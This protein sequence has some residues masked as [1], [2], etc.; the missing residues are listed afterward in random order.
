VSVIMDPVTLLVLL[1]VGA[2][3]SLLLWKVRWLAASNAILFSTL[4]AALVVYWGL[5][6]EM[7]LSSIWDFEVMEGTHLTVSLNWFSY[8]FLASVVV[9][10]PLVLL[11]SWLPMK[12]RQKERPFYGLFM[13]SLL[14]GAGVTLS[15]DLLTLFLFWEVMSWPVILLIGDG[16]ARSGRAMKTYFAFSMLSAGAILALL[17]LVRWAS[18]GIAFTD[19]ANAVLH[20]SNWFR[21]IVLVLGIVAFG[22]KG[23]VVPFHI[24]APGAYGHTEDPFSAFL[25]GSLSKTGIFGAFLVLDVFMGT[26]V[27][28]SYGSI[29]G[30]TTMGFSVALLGAATALVGGIMAMMQDDAKKLLAY[31]SI[32][33][34]GYVFVG[35]GVGGSTATAGALYHVLN[36]TIF[37]TLLF[38]GLGAVIYRTGEHKLSRM[39]GMIHVMPATFWCFLVGIFAAAAIPITSGLASKWLIYEGALEKGVGIIV[40]LL[41]LASVSA[42]LYSFR[43]LQGGFMGQLRDE[44]RDVKEAP[45][46]MLIPMVLLM[47]VLIVFAFVPGLPMELISRSMADLGMASPGYSTTVLNSGVGTYS[48]LVVML[49]VAGGFLLAAILFFSRPLGRHISLRDT[50][51]SGEEPMPNIDKRYHFAYRF[52]APYE[53]FLRPYFN[54]WIDKGWAK[55]YRFTSQIARL[56]RSIMNG[57]LTAYLWLIFAVLGLV[58]VIF[59]ASGGWF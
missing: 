17:A 53:R 32:S 25:S 45:L 13:L 55:L 31:S 33:Q 3:F 59:Y 12:D 46:S 9:M 20:G 16:R 28:M 57:D 41:F 56:H 10:A 38:M 2:V 14:G 11:Y 34:L 1:G 43:I 52:Y 47:V 54:K 58:G 37:K 27:L 18:G 51:T 26:A 15:R 39:G 5:S 35:L 7:P 36:H 44:F 30:L 19:A 42:F 21:I 29:N 8:L 23:A 4:G 50:F 24:W 49:G 40:P 48:G 22:T 6:G